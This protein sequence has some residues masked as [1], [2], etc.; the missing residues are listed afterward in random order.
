MEQYCPKCFGVYGGEV[1]FC[2][3]DGS[4]LVARKEG[5]LTGKTVDGRYL[6]L[7]R[8]GRGGMGVVYRA[9]QT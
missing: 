8:I 3:E 1:E 2:P 7:G 4:R 9:E 5:D 6:I